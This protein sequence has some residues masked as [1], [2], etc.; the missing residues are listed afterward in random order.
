MTFDCGL[1]FDQQVYNIVKISFIQRHL[2]AE[3]KPFL[4]R[5][6]LE[7][8][9]HALISSRLVYC[10]ARFVGLSKCI[11]QLRLFE[12]AASHFLVKLIACCRLT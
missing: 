12:N 5:C 2:L 6:D 3:V 7:K 4:N 10:N 1:K 9:I 8:I 11:S